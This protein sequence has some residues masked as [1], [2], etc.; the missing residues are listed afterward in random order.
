MRTIRSL[1]FGTYVR[2]FGILVLITLTVL[3]VHFQA[4][5]I[6]E[7]PLIDLTS[8]YVPV[9]HERS[10]GLA[11]KAHNIVKLTLNGREI[12]TDESGAFN[13]TLVLPNGYTIMELTA[14]DRF[15]RTTSVTRTYVYVPPSA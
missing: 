5:N 3:Y 6:L 7:G 15:G 13:Q 11:G 12:H 4:R 1:S 2:F 8:E 9:Q 10:V 14:Q